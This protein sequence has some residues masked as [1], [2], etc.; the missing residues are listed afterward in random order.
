VTADDVQAISAQWSPNDEQLLVRTAPTPLI[1]DYYMSSQYHIMSL[2]GETV[3]S[4]PTEGKLGKAEF[5]PNGQ[6][7]ALISAADYNDPSA[8]VLK[9]YNTQNATIRRV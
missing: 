1:D 9:V 6:Y 2:N 5:S 4:I 7:V 3:A 8:S